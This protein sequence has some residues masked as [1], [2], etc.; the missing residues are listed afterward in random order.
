M[1]DDQDCEDVSAAAQYIHNRSSHSSSINNSSNHNSSILDSISVGSEWTLATG[2]TG[3]TSALGL[4]TNHNKTTAEMVATKETFDRDRQ[5]TLQ[6]DMLQSEWTTPTTG[7]T[8]T[9]DPNSNNLHVYNNHN[10]ALQFQDATGQGE[11]IFIME[12]ATSSRR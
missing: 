2:V 5:I 1:E 9:T 12:P 6:K 3:V 4:T 7:T 8:G 11:E 10:S